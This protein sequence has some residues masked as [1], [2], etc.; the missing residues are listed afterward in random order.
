MNKVLSFSILYI[1]LFIIETICCFIIFLFYFITK[2][3]SIKDSFEVAI[4]WNLMRYLFFG[5]PFLIFYLLLFKYIKIINLYKPLLYSLFNVLIYIFL[6]ILS[7]ILIGEDVPLP[8]SGLIYLLTCVAIFLSP[9][10]LW[11]VPY[12]RK[13]MIIL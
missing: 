10:I 6:S 5:I 3:F 1:N 13:L 2:K 4:F 8:R 9:L 11:Q 12:F 7:R